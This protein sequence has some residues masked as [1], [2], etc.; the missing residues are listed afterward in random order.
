[1]VFDYFKKRASEGI[2]QVSAVKHDQTAAS[3]LDTHV[4]AVT[5]LQ[6]NAPHVGAA[7]VAVPT[8]Q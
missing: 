5:A 8:G 3:L 4:G 7:V 1:M 6:L 2:K